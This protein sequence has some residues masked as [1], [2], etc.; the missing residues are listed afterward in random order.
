MNSVKKFVLRA[1]CSNEYLDG[2]DFFVVE[3]GPEYARLLLERIKLLQAVRAKDDEA[4]EL[5]FWDYSGDYFGG[6]PDEQDGPSEPS[7]TECHQLVARE[8]EVLWTAIPKHTDVTVTTDS[9]KAADLAE[10]A[11]SLR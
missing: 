7:R 1:S 5:Y 4:Y 3:I 2:F 11:G 10:V 8:D 9:I 6:D